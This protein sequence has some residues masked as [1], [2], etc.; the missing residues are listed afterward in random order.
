[1]KRFFVALAL[2]LLIIRAIDAQAPAP[3]VVQAVTPPPAISSS[4]APAASPAAAD[5]N[6][7][8]QMLQE[9]QTS[10]LDTIKKQEAALQTL[11]TLQKAAADIKIYSKRG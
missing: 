2:G 11:D 8:I 10:N 6:E 3:V 4:P 1:V 9:M 7:A 5:L